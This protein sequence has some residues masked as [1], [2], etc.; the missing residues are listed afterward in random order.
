MKKI[1][2]YHLFGNMHLHNTETKMKSKIKLKIFKIIYI[3]VL[4]KKNKVKN[5]TDNSMTLLG[6]NIKGVRNS[7]SKKK[8]FQWISSEISLGYINTL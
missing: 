3:S 4:P 1:L 8:L 2:D 5:I 6:I 7:K